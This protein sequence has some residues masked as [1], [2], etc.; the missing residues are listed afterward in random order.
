MKDCFSGTPKP[1]RETRA[2]PGLEL[3]HW[4][5]RAEQIPIAVDVV[6][7]GNYRPEFVV[8][9]PRRGKSC[10]FARVGAVPFVGRDLSRGVRRVLKQIA[11]PIM[12]SVGDCLHLRVN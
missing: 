6:D 8:A 7:A 10:L 2:L 12:F 9:R 1:A 5:A 4:R 11:L 3:F